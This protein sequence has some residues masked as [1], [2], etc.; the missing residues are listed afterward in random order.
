MGSENHVSERVVN[1]LLTEMDGLED[2]N[3]VL[4]IAATN[5]PDMVD[6]ALL[7]PGRFDRMILTPVPDEKTRLEIFNVHTKGMPISLENHLPKQKIIL[8]KEIETSTKK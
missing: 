8:T 4:V 5:R 6:T 2:L 1:Q 7:R 3:D